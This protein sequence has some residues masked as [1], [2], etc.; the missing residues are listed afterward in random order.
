MFSTFRVSTHCL[1]I[2]SEHKSAQGEVK[3]VPVSGGVAAR[4][5]ATSQGAPVDHTRAPCQGRRCIL[6]L[7]S[8]K[9][10]LVP[11]YSTVISITEKRVCSGLIIGSVLCRGWVCSGLCLGLFGF[12]YIWSAYHKQVNLTLFGML[13]VKDRMV[14]TTDRVDLARSPKHVQLIGTLATLFH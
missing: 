7:F 13:D 10:H 12:R 1:Y 5:V 2:I 11:I 3:G 9:T 8:L 4:P 6:P 14:L